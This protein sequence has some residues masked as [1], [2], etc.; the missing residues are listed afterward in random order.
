MKKETLV[1]AVAEERNITVVEAGRTIDT[2]LETIAKA[3]ER[4][5][6]VVLQNYFTFTAK[7]R[8]ERKARNLAT[9]QPMT[10]PAYVTATC[11][12]AKRLRKL[13]V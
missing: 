8:A 7:P 12:F 9:G 11:R 3:L 5:E 4:H 6:Q 2:F 10:V 1:K 13:P